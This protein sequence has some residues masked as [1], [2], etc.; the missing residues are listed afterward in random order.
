VS[1]TASFSTGAVNISLSTVTV[2]TPQLSA[3]GT[4]AVSVTVNAGGV[5]TTTPFNVSFTSP[6]ARNGK[7]ALTSAV[8]T[9][10]GVATASYRDIGCAGTDTITASVTGLALVST[11]VVT[12]SPPAVG[13]IQYVAATPTSISLR[14]TGGLGRQETSQVSFRVVDIGGNP[15]GGRT[16]TFNLNTTV[17]GISL[18]ATT[19]TS[20]PS[21]G[22]V[23]TNVQ[24]GTV[25][26]PVRVTASTIAGAQTLTTQSDQ[27]TITTGI[28]AQD[29]FSISLS[30][31]NIEGWNYDG[32][33][34]QV[35]VRMADHFKNPVPDGTAVTFTAEGAS[36]VGSCLTVGGLCSVTFTS[37]ALRPV[38]GRVTVLAY[39]VGEEGF[40]D[41]NG[42]G[43]FDLSPT[44]ELI[45]SNKQSTDIG[46]AFVDFNENGVRDATEP[47]IDFNNNGVFDGPDGKYSG[48][49]CDETVAGRSPAGSCAAAK[50]LHVRGSHTVVLSGSEPKAELEVA[51]I[52]NPNP[53]LLKLTCGSAPVALKF[54]LEDA[55]GNALPA[56]TLVEYTTTNGKFASTTSFVI[57]NSLACRNPGTGNCPASAQELRNTFAGSFLTSI[58]SDAELPKC[59]NTNKFGTLT[60]KVTTPKNIVTLFSSLT[61]ED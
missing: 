55:R 30:T 52:N 57:P 1:G 19:A 49:L 4:T 20:D 28:P 36:I 10:N 29:S 23:V 32:T 33:T 38:T 56:G 5:A 16:V 42:N 18:S 60:L 26:T 2:A 31:F 48:V 11:G 14:G 39:A 61:I 6:C 25:S 58:Q 21:T 40:T 35:T 8:A 37:Q 45:D 46:E 47:F 24:A 50:T 59:E 12:V 51:G 17:G 7:A 54:H 15:L 41:L 27:L 22:L 3:F 9:I 43:W 44:N 13:S 34:T 53:S